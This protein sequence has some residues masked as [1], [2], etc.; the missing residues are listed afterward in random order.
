MSS[1]RLLALTVPMPFFFDK[2]DD[3]RQPSARTVLLAP[4]TATFREEGSAF[5]DTLLALD[6][7][8]L[9]EQKSGLALSEQA[10]APG[11]PV[12]AMPFQG[13]GEGSVR[14]ESS[15]PFSPASLW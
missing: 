5:L 15:I 8:L 9:I 4:S 7:K 13:H 11:D 10:D 2:A 3:C 1:E 6:D 14:H 12:F